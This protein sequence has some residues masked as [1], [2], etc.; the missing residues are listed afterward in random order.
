M[1]PSAFNPPRKSDDDDGAKSG[2]VRANSQSLSNESMPSLLISE[3]VVSPVEE[4]EEILGHTPIEDDADSD[5]IQQRRQQNHNIHRIDG[6]VGMPSMSSS[7]E[8]DIGG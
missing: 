7:S 8:W 3:G 1:T 6:E 2:E 4:E 5:S